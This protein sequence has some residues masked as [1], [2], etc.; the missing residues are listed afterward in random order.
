MDVFN[1]TNSTSNTDTGRIA[2]NS[3]GT[4]CNERSFCKL[5]SFAHGL[6]D[7]YH[8][9]EDNQSNDCNGK[10]KNKT[11]Q[12]KRKNKKSKPK[13]KAKAKTKRTLKRQ[14]DNTL[15]GD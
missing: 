1:R 14:K 15:H 5:Q 13:S 11:S 6:S 8:S 3:N 2:L 10:P 9:D 12:S 4:D 7:E